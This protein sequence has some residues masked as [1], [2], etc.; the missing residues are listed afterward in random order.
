LQYA[1]LK[2]L[3]IFRNGS[4][5][6]YGIIKLCIA[7][8][9]L[10]FVKQNNL[11]WMAMSELHRTITDMGFEIARDALRAEIE[12]DGGLRGL[13][14]TLRDPDPAVSRQAFEK[15]GVLLSAATSDEQRQRRAEEYEANPMAWERRAEVDTLRIAA[16][17]IH[18]EDAPAM[19][20]A[21]HV[22]RIAYPDGQPALG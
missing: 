13:F 8:L 3:R 22:H 17:G 15:Y 6:I 21:M 1:P 9:L 16:E 2:I 20:V 11:D 5:I 12:A 19:L 4:G 7:R 10:F 14:D 18:E